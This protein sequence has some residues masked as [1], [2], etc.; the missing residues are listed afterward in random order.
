MASVQTM[1]EMLK[2]FPAASLGGQRVIGAE[3]SCNMLGVEMSVPRSVCAIVCTSRWSS[4][5][6][7]TRSPLWLMPQRRLTNSC[8]SQWV[9]QMPNLSAL[10]WSTW[11]FFPSSVYYRV[12]PRC[13]CQIFAALTVA[14]GRG[15][16]WGFLKAMKFRHHT[17]PSVLTRL[18]Y[19]NQGATPL[20]FAILTCKFEAARVLVEAGA[21]LDL[22]NDRGKTALDFLEEMQAPFVFAN[23][24][25]VKVASIASSASVSW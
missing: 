6:M 1:K 2:H 17:S 16:W 13:H 11:Q 12:V 9:A 23:N 4:L 3:K 14:K 5:V 10:S 24:S 7:Q 25:V 15:V 21:R 20:M 8:E 19:H 22:R 18:A